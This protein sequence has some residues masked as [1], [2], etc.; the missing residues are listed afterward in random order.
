MRR[1]VK[2]KIAIRVLVALAVTFAS[3]PSLGAVPQTIQYRYTQSRGFVV[4]AEEGQAL[5]LGYIQ[6]LSQLARKELR[7]SVAD[8]IPTNLSTTDSDR[9]LA[10]QIIGHSIERWLSSSSIAQESFGEVIQAIEAPLDQS[11]SIKDRSGVEHKIGFGVK[12][13]R[14]I[15][16]LNYTGIVEATLAYQVTSNTLGLEIARR[17]GAHQKLVV[18]HIQAASEVRETIAWQMDW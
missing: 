10:R 18:N 15:A 8:Y 11:V 12:A 16:S 7:M 14:A 9:T 17:I 5:D 3:I 2:T 1:E 6:R 13:A 4:Q